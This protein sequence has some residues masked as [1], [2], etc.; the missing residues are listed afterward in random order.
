M[1]SSHR[2]YAGISFDFDF[3]PAHQRVVAEQIV[4]A[5]NRLTSAQRR[6]A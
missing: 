4:Q 5:I 2:I 3:N 6:A 1:D